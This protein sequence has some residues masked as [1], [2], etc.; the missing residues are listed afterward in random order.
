MDKM[1]LKNIKAGFNGSLPLTPPQSPSSS[2]QATATSI[3]SQ[4]NNLILANETRINNINSN[5]NVN[6]DIRSFNNL[7]VKKEAT[8]FSVIRS[9]QKPMISDSQATLPNSNSN[10]TLNSN[11]NSSTQ[12]PN[13]ES[14]S[15]LNTNSYSNTEIP[16][17]ENKDIKSNLDT[18]Q[19]QVPVD[20]EASVQNIT[21]NGS[22]HNVQRSDSKTIIRKNTIEENDNS[23]RS[24]SNDLSIESNNS[25][26]SINKHRQTTSEI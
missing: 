23:S 7:S 24:P 20:T 25:A 5:E 16:N 26:Y 9:N 14:N 4:L 12:I 13:S 11:T 1:N 19:S 10:S 17:L 18:N 15:T 6:E 2:N 21:K 3:K 8:S 22:I